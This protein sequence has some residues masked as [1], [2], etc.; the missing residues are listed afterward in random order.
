MVF[1][2][3]GE[4]ATELRHTVEFTVT[5]DGPI[6]GLPKHCNNPVRVNTSRR[7]RPCLVRMAVGARAQ[8]GPRRRVLLAQCRDRRSIGRNRYCEGGRTWQRVQ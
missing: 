8:L 5:G 2:G 4:I 7:A 1:V 3:V 6:F